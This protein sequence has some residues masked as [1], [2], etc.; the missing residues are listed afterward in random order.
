MQ[1]ID[2]EESEG[3]ALERYLRVWVNYSLGDMEEAQV[4]EFHSALVNQLSRPDMVS[5]S[6][7]VPASVELVSCKRLSI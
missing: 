3:V 6:A 4:T 7:T 2:A 5:S 1:K